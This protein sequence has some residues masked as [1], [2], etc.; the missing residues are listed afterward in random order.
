MAVTPGGRAD[1]IAQVDSTKFFALPAE[2]RMSVG[3]LFDGLR[4]PSG[5]VLFAQSQDNR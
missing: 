4:E 1:S 5:R 2:E 3:Q